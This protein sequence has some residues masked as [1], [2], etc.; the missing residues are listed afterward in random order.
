MIEGFFFEQMAIQK[1]NQSK[2]MEESSPLES[3]LPG[4]EERRKE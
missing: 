4:K 1:E 2:D 3:F